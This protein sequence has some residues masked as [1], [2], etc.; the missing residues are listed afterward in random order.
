MTALVEPARILLPP[1]LSSCSLV[2]VRQALVGNGLWLDFGAVTLRVR[3]DSRL[4]AAQLQRVYPNFGLATSGD[5]ADLHVDLRAPGGI[6]RWLARQVVF[7]CDGQ[8]PFDPFPADSPLPLLEWGGNW[9]IG[10][11]MN[12]LLLLHAGAVERN[13]LA[14][15]LPAVPGSGKST[16]T[17]ALSARGWRLLS[18]EFGAV[19]PLLGTVH[20]ILKPVALKNASIGVIRSF[21]PNSQFGPEF[22]RTRK[23]TVAHL[24]ADADSVARRHVSAEP[25]A[26]ILPKWVAG[27]ATK[28]QPMSQD[29]LFP[30]LA[31]NAFNYT[32]LGAA[33]FDAAIRLTRRCL[34]WTLVYSDL[35][36]AVATIDSVW[37]Q[38]MDRHLVAAS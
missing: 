20:A 16:L 26:V 4:L 31:F 18:D 29:R 30:A 1:T 37:P 25:A 28:L 3:S 8:Q 21:A 33:G 35:E 38:V 23:G 32:T 17:A 9:L 10:R 7:R 13:G 15:L 6:R 5:W 34:A 19:D 36:D 24:A 12:D 27:S 14:L 2:A 22:P 11:R